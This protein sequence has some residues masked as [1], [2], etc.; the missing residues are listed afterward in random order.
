MAEDMSTES[1]LETGERIAIETL[2]RRFCPQ[3]DSLKVMRASRNVVVEI[4]EGRKA[5]IL[6]ARDAGAP[7]ARKVANEAAWISHL[8][9]SG[10]RVPCLVQSGS[11]LLVE[12]SPSGNHAFVGY[13]YE[14]IP[15]DSGRSECWDDPRFIQELG[16]TAGRMHV[17]AESFQLPDP[18]NMPGWDTPEWIR[19]PEGFFHPSQRGA[20]GTI[21]K[22]RRQVS[23]LQQRQGTCGLVHDDLHTGNVFKDDDGL[24]IIDFECLHVN[25]FVAEIASAL[26]FRTWI[27]P[28]KET[29]DVEARALDFLRNLLLGYTNEHP[30][31]D[32]WYELMPLFLKLREISLFAAYAGIDMNESKDNALVNY[33]Y[34][35]VAENRPFLKTDF[36]EVL[37]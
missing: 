22:L 17:L 23:E 11:G 25:R 20:V 8:Y 36:R 35:S 9:Q 18:G 10:I 24:V 31:E 32:T 27:G 12:C 15:L 37:C 21:L 13:C 28:E 2:A 16:S 4:G 3:Y 26:L 1:R 6:K 14:K 33:I 34:E 7:D 19:D 29:P 30:L 5:F